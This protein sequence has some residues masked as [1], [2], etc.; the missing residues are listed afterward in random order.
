MQ[1]GDKSWTFVPAARRAFGAKTR[2]P[3]DR[4]PMTERQGA[5]EITFALNDPRK[6]I[7]P[8]HSDLVRARDS[9]QRRD[10]VA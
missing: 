6:I 4:R 2:R 8:Q 5:I 7:L 9:I 1:G 3:Q 10:K